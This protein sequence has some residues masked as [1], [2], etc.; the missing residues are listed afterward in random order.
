M[1]ENDKNVLVTPT[2]QTEKA[3]KETMGSLIKTLEDYCLSN[4]L[5]KPVFQT[6]CI[7]SKNHEVLA[8]VGSYEAKGS[9]KLYHAK[10]DAVNNLLSELK[11][12]E[13]KIQ[14]EK[15]KK[16]NIQIQANISTNNLNSS[17]MKDQNVLDTP[18]IKAKMS[19]EEIQQKILQMQQ[20]MQEQNSTENLGF[21]S[22]AC[23]EPNTQ[24][25]ANKS[26]D[27][28]NSSLM[29][30]GSW[31]WIEGLQGAKDLNG[32]LGQIVKFNKDKQ[33]YE[34]FIPDSNGFNS[35]DFLPAKSFLDKIH[36]VSQIEFIR[37]IFRQ[38]DE[39]SLIG[40]KTF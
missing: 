29:K 15:L 35:R 23:K 30:Q 17:L 10:R 25:P 19:K 14:T 9:G 7:K 18:N 5:P 27:N 21:G 38:E 36:T 34:V 6:N 11:G 28:L 24:I 26:T 39:S 13:T 32:K 40:E 20:Q 31:I 3:N 22:E 1:D 37:K 8:K 4:S 16:E 12:L 33:R 2:V